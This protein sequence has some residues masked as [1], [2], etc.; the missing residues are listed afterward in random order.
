MGLHE[1][2]SAIQEKAK[3]EIAAA[4]EVSKQEADRIIAEAESRVSDRKQKHSE[5]TTRMIETLERKEQASMGFKRKSRLLEE[6]RRQIDAVFTEVNHALSEQNASERTSILHNLAIKAKAE[7][8]IT[9]IHC[10]SRDVSALSKE[11][12][13]AKI[14]ANKSISGGFLADDSTGTVRLDYTYET[15]LTQVREEHTNEL[16]EQLFPE[17]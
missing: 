7:A 11:F 4:R 6:K 3:A 8:D 16:Y 13:D 1:V 2:K 9:L 14:T 5:E 15:I 17:R 10:A 12:P